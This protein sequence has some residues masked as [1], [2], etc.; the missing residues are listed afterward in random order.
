MA[1]LRKFYGQL[2]V[3]LWW[4]PD[5]ATNFSD[6]FFP[7]LLAATESSY[8]W[9][10]RQDKPGILWPHTNEPQPRPLIYDEAA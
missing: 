2:I 8:K 9:I 10:E 1:K 6:S 5:K 7:S 4:H 3:G